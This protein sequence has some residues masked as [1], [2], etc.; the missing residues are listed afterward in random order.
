[1]DEED[2]TGAYADMESVQFKPRLEKEG[3]FEYVNIDDSVLDRL[4]TVILHVFFLFPRIALSPTPHLKP[5]KV[6]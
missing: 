1:M 6:D 4:P 2:Y 5:I 3:E